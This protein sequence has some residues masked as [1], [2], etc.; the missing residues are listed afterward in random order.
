MTI[1]VTVVN[2]QNVAAMIC[3]A[4]ASVCA[5]FA[6]DEPEYMHTIY[7]VGL[8]PTAY[9][10]GKCVA[11][12]STRER[13]MDVVGE[14]SELGINALSYHSVYGSDGALYPTADPLLKRSWLWP[15]E[16]RPVDDFLAACEQFGVEAW[17]GVHLGQGGYPLLA[18][19]ALDDIVRNFGEHPALTGLVPPIE[20]RYTGVNAE[21]FAALSRHV[22]QARPDLQIMDYPS[23][24]YVPQAMQWLMR[25][26]ASG[27]V[28][29]E[30]VQF[31]AC[32]DRLAD[33]REARGLTLLTIGVCP[34]TRTIIHAHYKNGVNTPQKPSIWLPPERAWDVTQSALMTA[35]PH[36]TSIFSFLH[37]CWGEQS[38][39]PGGEAMWRRLKW[40]EGIVGVQRL[41]PYYANAMPADRVQVMVPTGTL[42][43]AQDILRQC[44]LPLAREHIPASFCVTE[45][46]MAPEARVVIVPALTQCGREQGLLLQRF[47]REGGR[48]L[49]FGGLAPAEERYARV[50]AAGPI[51]PHMRDV[52]DLWDRPDLAVRDLTEGFAGALGFGD[53]GLAAVTQPRNTPYGKGTVSV[54]PG[55]VEWAE[56]HLAAVVSEALDD[57]WRVTNLPAGYVVERWRKGET[58]MLLIFGIE[59]G[60]EARDV[61]IALPAGEAHRGAWLIEGEQASQLPT[62]V[63]ADTGQQSVLIKRLGDSFAL[64]VLGEC[65][66]AVLRP[67]AR[68]IR[69][70]V[71]ETVTVAASLLNA[72]GGRVT[73]ELG[74][75]APEGWSVTRGGQ[76]EYALDLGEEARF[77]LAVTVPAEAQRRPYF[78][79]LTVGEVTQRVIVFPE[80]GAAQVITEREGPLAMQRPPVEAGPTGPIGDEWLKVTAGEP[81][82]NAVAAHR[83]GVCFYPGEWAN[84]REHMG[85]IARYAEYIALG[86]G[87]PNF[88]INDPDRTDNAARD[89]LMRITCIAP[90]GGRVQVFDGE[91]YHDVGEME[92]GEQWRTDTWTVSRDIFA[93]ATAN[94]GRNNPGFNVLGQFNAPTIR[95]HSIEVRM[96]PL[97][98]DEE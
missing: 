97:D 28:D 92:A 67:E 31:H 81:G 54:L 26:A 46:N 68:T 53:E 34:G 40:Y 43:G 38:S 33:L 5:V 24:P 17:L 76:L 82:D 69:S 78:V 19:H 65:P 64:V 11:D 71:G 9:R 48:L 45:E 7:Y 30:N 39:D 60:L 91:K 93:E 41:V 84:A 87:G 35:T 70:T 98:D 56:E 88:W 66:R 6:Q 75:A 83:P 20:A 12:I 95:I 63:D 89:L 90:E 8:R 22:K 57:G 80:D 10:Q 59:K 3:I 49:T 77:E 4:L 79:K 58:E 1:R 25:L 61:R 13:V 37:A 18:E 32:D 16:A 62:S 44:W 29:V 21:S 85:K 72:T 23:S 42:Q 55:A 14:L 50:L 15:E 47:V 2:W 73:G 52:L 51:T 74:A 86:M 94:Y 27:Q 96:S 36:G